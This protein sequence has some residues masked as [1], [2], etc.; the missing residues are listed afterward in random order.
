MRN[1]ERP[2]RRQV[3][4]RSWTLCSVVCAAFVMSPAQA[5]NQTSV[6]VPVRPA[7]QLQISE[8]EL[9]LT[10]DNANPIALKI[11]GPRGTSKQTHAM[12]LT[13]ASFD[14]FD[15]MVPGP[16]VCFTE[17]P[18]PNA[19]VNDNAVVIK[20]LHG[21]SPPPET[22]KLRVLLQFPRVDR[23]QCTGGITADER[24]TIDVVGGAQRITGVSILSFDR[25]TQSPPVCTTGR[26]V[27]PAGEG[28]I[29]LVV[30]TPKPATNVIVQ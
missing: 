20:P 25:R 7:G 30:R 3:V 8:V 5:A 11:T 13:D 27:L 28:A 17:I 26:R 22:N 9:T 18:T 19:P 23:A 15:D 21:T 4:R 2:S 12:V 6:I 10:L 16:R 24:W 14:C 29:E 1:S